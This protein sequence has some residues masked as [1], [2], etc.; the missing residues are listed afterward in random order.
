MWKYGISLAAP[1][2]LLVRKNS[3]P[4]KNF[5]SVGGNC[6]LSCSRFGSVGPLQMSCSLRSVK[7]G[8]FTM[9]ALFALS[10][11]SGN[12]V[13]VRSAENVP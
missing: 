6:M 12:V 3:L 5:G 10:R 4:P 8:T 9:P 2:S 7:A 11:G 1:H 13:L